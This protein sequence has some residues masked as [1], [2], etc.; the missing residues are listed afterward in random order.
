MKLTKSTLKR[1]IKEEIENLLD[2]SPMG[3][4]AKGA[5]GAV[6]K[7]AGHWTD[8]YVQK[9]GEHGAALQAVGDMTDM[10]GDIDD[11]LES[12]INQSYEAEDNELA[13]ARRQMFVVLMDKSTSHGEKRR[14]VNK[15]LKDGLFGDPKSPEAKKEWR[16]LRRIVAKE[17]RKAERRNSVMT[18]GESRPSMNPDGTAK[19]G[20]YSAA[21]AKS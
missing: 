11:S 13:G 12:L 17:K 2:E 19:G 20:D 4:L 1:L 5:M 9:A 3:A 16:R 18:P 14:T 7:G 15:A 10:A 21:L 8:E 6:A